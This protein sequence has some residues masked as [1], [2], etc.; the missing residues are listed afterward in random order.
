MDEVLMVEILR[1]VSLAI[2]LIGI[3]TGLDLIFG[4]KV[5]LALKRFLDQVYNFDKT[6]NEP[7]TRRGLG[8]VM[9]S[10]SL[11]MWFLLVTTK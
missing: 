2:S 6:I 10:V 9:L 5:I 1:R 3:L 8:V 11:V 4:A 7:K